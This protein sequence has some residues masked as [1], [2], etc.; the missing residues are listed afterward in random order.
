MSGKDKNLKTN[1]VPGLLCMLL[2]YE[3]NASVCRRAPFNRSKL[4]LSAAST[5][6]L[7]GA[8]S[9]VRAAPA[10]YYFLQAALIRLVMDQGAGGFRQK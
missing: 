7:G 10:D 6:F 1:R 2:W 3:M 4:F 8:A 5:P 9:R